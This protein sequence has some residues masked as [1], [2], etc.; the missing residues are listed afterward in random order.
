ME[1]GDEVTVMATKIERTYGVASEGDHGWVIG[2]TNRGYRVRFGEFI[3]ENVTASQ[4][5]RKDRRQE[6]RTITVVGTAGGSTDSSLSTRSMPEQTTSE[7]T[8]SGRAASDGTQ[9]EVPR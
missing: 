5:G 7:P 8:S 6:G 9:T 4:I 3:A 1:V 2:K